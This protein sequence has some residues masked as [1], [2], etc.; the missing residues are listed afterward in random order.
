MRVRWSLAL[1]LAC[2]LAL[3]VTEKN[4]SVQIMNAPDAEHGKYLA[5]IACAFCHSPAD[6]PAFSGQLIE[7][8]G[9]KFYAPNLTSS[10]SGLGAWTDEE[11][12][13]A[14]TRG[15][16]L[17]GRQLHSMMPYLY[18][19]RM[20]DMD[21]DDLIAYLRSL[22]PVNSPEHPNSNVADITLPPI[23]QRES[24]ISAPNSEN[25]V[26]YGEYLVNAVLACGSCHT[27]T[28]ADGL[29]VADLALAG[30]PAFTGEWGTVYASNIT[31]DKT[32]GIGSFTDERILLAVIS[33]KALSENRPLYA[34]PWQSYS[35]LSGSDAQAMLDYLRS[36]DAI[37]NDVPLA[38]LDSG[39]EVY[40]ANA[41]QQAS[42]ES[43]VLTIIVLILLGA[44][45]IYLMM[46]Q[47][48]QNQ[49]LRTIDWEGHFQSVLTE[50]PNEQ[51]EEV[52]PNAMPRDQADETEV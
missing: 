9:E 13:E 14:I 23:P 26:A 39:Y 42:W 4:T 29:P 31:P 18:F 21:A 19:N 50:A 40:P 38:K 51:D 5:E 33:G 44:G 37:E 34:M 32:T 12:R 22:P 8:G 11:V 15:V 48:R 27:A 49:R 1:M 46:R 35:Q 43:I 52:I 30:G 6:K 45:S 16:R 47:Y 17:D 20:A 41:K 10:D 36:L 2:W 3:L 7:R 25:S 24:P 28:Q